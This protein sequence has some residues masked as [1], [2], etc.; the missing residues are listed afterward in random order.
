MERAN[1]RFFEDTRRVAPTIILPPRTPASEDEK[2]MRRELG[3][4]SDRL[5]KLVGP[6]GVTDSDLIRQI[7]D[8][9]EGFAE[10]E[11]LGG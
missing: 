9:A 3:R 7:R 6:L 4:E 1:H 10:E 11:E 5:A 2:A 8:E